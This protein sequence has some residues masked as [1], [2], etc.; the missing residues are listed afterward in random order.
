MQTIHKKQAA[1]FEAVFSKKS[2][3]YFS[4]IAFG[5]ALIFLASC[6]LTKDVEV[7]LPAYESQPVVECYL[8]PGQPMTLLLSKSSPYFE[9]LGQ[10]SQWLGK[11]FLDSALV[12]I[13]Y[14]AH[15][16]TLKNQ[17]FF[18]PSTGKIYN[19]YS[20]TIVQEIWGIEYKLEIRLKN[21][22]T[23]S[24]K[25]TVIEPV[26]IDSVRVEWNPTRD[27]LARTILY[28]TDDP[29]TTDFYR[30]MLHEHSLDSSAMQDFVLDDRLFTDKLVSFGGGYDFTEQDSKHNALQSNCLF[31]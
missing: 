10:A 31:S 16:D 21:G 2:T 14:P 24:A 26:K 8:E 17:L 7:V 1:F 20:P 25:T 18:N 13:A 4:K 11:L 27:T 30:R 12:T 5:A 23:I 19:Y 28:T 3:M 6:N 15:T 22:E 9:P 29:A